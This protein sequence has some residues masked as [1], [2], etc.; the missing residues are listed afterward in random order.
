MASTS[1]AMVQLGPNQLEAREFPVPKIGEQDGLLRVERCG[2]C[3]SDVEQLNGDLTWVPYPVIPGHEPVGI[4]EAVGSEAA[5]RWGVEVGDRVIV[6]SPIPCRRCT[7]C[8][9]GLFNSCSNRMNVGYVPID[10]APSL[11]GGYAEYLY[12]HPNV[13]M[14]KLSPKVPAEIA[15]FYNPLACGVGWAAQVG[16]IELGQTVVV[17]GAGQ[18][19]LAC[20]IVAKA[21]GAETVIMTGLT[22]DENKLSIA[23]ELGIDATIDVQREDVVERV[24]EVTGGGMADVVIDVV[25]NVP[26]T[27]TDA[28]EL[29]KHRG[30]VVIAAMKGDVE[31]P[32]FFSDRIALKAL[33][34]RGAL[35][36]PSSAYRLAISI[37][38][39]GR[40]PF[41][42]LQPRTYALEDATTAIDALAGRI[43]GENP[44][45]VSLA[46]GG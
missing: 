28:L 32:G 42:K 24:R 16:Q 3:G 1:L 36:K 20:G 41:E 38:E 19:G 29:A 40:F 9:E 10:V 18:R 8:A 46:P 30:T 44:I 31:V 43:P 12:L 22:K 37:L 21:V 34:I 26:T 23:R 11:F 2:I 5:R 33:S 39:S 14:H 7:F 27:F 45:C 35:G 15:P 13:T 6:E 25:P 17:L 4:I